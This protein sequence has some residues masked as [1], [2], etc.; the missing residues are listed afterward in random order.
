MNEKDHF[1]EFEAF[2]IKKI[3]NCAQ[4]HFVSDITEDLIF[5][6]I[7]GKAAEIAA[8]TRGQY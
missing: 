6:V 2:E 3:S 5:C 4:K 1:C 7:C 8:Y